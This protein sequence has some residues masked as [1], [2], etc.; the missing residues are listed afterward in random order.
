MEL[1]LNTW[2]S[3]YKTPA[4]HFR[5]DLLLSSTPGCGNL[6]LSR[7][8]RQLCES[9]WRHNFCS[10]IHSKEQHLNINYNQFLQ[11]LWINT[12]KATLPLSFNTCST[13]GCWWTCKPLPS[14][15]ENPE[16]TS[17][18]TA[19]LLTQQAEAAPEWNL[20]KGWK[21]GNW[22]QAAMKWN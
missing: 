21:N 3:R 17:S 6:A 19:S 12:G 15:C 7:L 16:G 10:Y 20:K 4:L 2:T 18:K 22:N 13:F 1:W 9:Q 8:S 5:I 14:E 11:A